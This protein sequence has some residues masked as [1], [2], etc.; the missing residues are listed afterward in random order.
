MAGTGKRSTDLQS[1]L[2]DEQ[3]GTK[4]ARSTPCNFL[5]CRAHA[6]VSST[7]LVPSAVC[8]DASTAARAVDGVVDRNEA[9]EL[10]EWARTQGFAFGWGKDDTNACRR[11]SYRS[12]YTIEVDDTALA[13]RLWR[14]LRHAL[15]NPVHVSS[16][17]CDD[18]S[19]VGDW[20]AVGLHPRILFVEYRDGGHFSP[21][22]DGF[23]VASMHQ[24][25]LFTALVYLNDVDVGGK[26]AWLCAF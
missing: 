19:G 17:D 22:S 20:R 14:R 16:V 25:S 15:P 12:A 2:H 1:N 21:H 8:G 11:K 7:R 26:R 10:I 5:D 9:E 23:L 6:C 24:R 13:A 18:P 3:R 4:R